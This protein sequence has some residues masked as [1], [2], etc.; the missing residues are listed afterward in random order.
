VS[1]DLHPDK[2]ENDNA[3]MIALNEIKDEAMKIFKAIEARE[4][5]E[6]AAR[7]T[8]KRNDAA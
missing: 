2:L 5:K 3:P 6:R 8:E 7:E 4:E 1:L